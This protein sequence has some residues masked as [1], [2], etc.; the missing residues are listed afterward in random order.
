MRWPG[1][2]KLVGGMRPWLTILE[3]LWPLRAVHAYGVFPPN[4]LPDY[5]WMAV[6]EGSFDG[7]TWTR[8]PFRYLTTDVKHPPKF[9]APH[10][11]RLDH[12]IFYIGLGVAEHTWTTTVGACTPYTVT[13]S[14]IDRRIMA[15]LLDG[16]DNPIYDLFDRSRNPFSD[17]NKPP[18]YLRCTTYEM[19]SSSQEHLNKTG[20]YYVE[21]TM[22]R[23][24]GPITK[25]DVPGIWEDWLNPVELWHWDAM[26]WRH[27]A[28]SFPRST[29]EE[30]EMGWKFMQEVRETAAT[31]A[32]ELSDW[33]R[34]N[35]WNV[36]GCIAMSDAEH[37]FDWETMP[38]T[39][40]RV[41]HKWSSKDR[42]TAELALGRMHT[43]LISMLDELAF[44]APP[45]PAVLEEEITEEIH[46]GAGSHADETNNDEE[47]HE[48]WQSEYRNLDKRIRLEPH[49]ACPPESPVGT[50]FRCAQYCQLLLLLGG[51][52]AFERAVRGKEC[53]VV[54]AGAYTLPT[55][56]DVKASR[57]T[58]A[59]IFRRMNSPEFNWMHLGV[60]VNKDPGQLMSLYMTG[61]FHYNVLAYVV[62][63][64]QVQALM[65]HGNFPAGGV[66]PGFLVLNDAIIRKRC[67]RMYD[68]QEK[69]W[70]PRCDLTVFATPDDAKWKP[71]GSTH[72]L[73][74]DIFSTLTP[75]MLAERIK[76]RD[77]R[78][79]TNPPAA[80]EAADS[81]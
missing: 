78:A 15:C 59:G 27:L 41:W 76:A 69:C 54:G 3:F 57:D 52:E 64:G 9:V 35:D 5:R 2:H 31:V 26:N 36:N 53:A 23:H 70:L 65:S 55:K 51:R 71:V 8:I 16:A 13:R 21:R 68:P 30:Y 43:Q 48:W 19:H 62:T 44:R 49:L 33:R 47:D 24:G 28:E 60:D 4:S 37:I 38:E 6:F 1:F 42:R 10:H 63:R 75:E 74:D 72:E 18:I 46:A 7:K 20:E 39:W 17:P 58:L 40:R 11:P 29:S 34:P 77:A 25:E 45:G 56:Y 79:K 61:V 67:I 14:G 66:L 32:E 73:G 22:G 50:P 80:E 81:Q 12:G